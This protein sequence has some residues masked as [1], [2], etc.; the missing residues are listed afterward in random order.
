[1][2]GAGPRGW[3]AKER[4]P[5]LQLVSG[6]LWSLLQMLGHDQSRDPHV[7]SGPHARAEPTTQLVPYERGAPRRTATRYRNTNTA[8]R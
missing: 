5:S 3:A 1:M 4:V 8:T 2:I 7:H 6:A